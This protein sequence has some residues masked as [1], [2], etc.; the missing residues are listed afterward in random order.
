MVQ[1]KPKINKL[2]KRILEIII[3]WN[4]LSTD[5][6]QIELHEAKKI[7]VLNSTDTY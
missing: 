1:V 3:L 5:L 2:Q 6:S 4:I 7:K